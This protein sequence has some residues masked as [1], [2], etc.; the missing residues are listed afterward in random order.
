[1]AR[2]LFR[3][4]DHAGSIPVTPTNE[5]DRPPGGDRDF[6]CRL[7]WV[8]VPRLLRMLL[9]YDGRMPTCG[10]CSVRFPCR[11]TVGGVLRNVAGRKYCLVCSPFGRHNTTDPRVR[12]GLPVTCPCGRQFV[13]SK[14]KGHSHTKCNSCMSNAHRRGRKLRAIEYKGGKCE[15]C[16]Y[17]RCVGSLVFHHKD[18]A[19]KTFQVS[20]GTFSWE[21][22]RAEIDKCLLL[23][24][25]CHGEVHHTPL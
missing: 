22:V 10:L 21:R 2:H 20:F 18:P 6:T 1:M 8:R 23:C 15:M 9:C 14:S 16:G 7:R 12:T 5:G 17:S 25:N 24:A 11:V 13:Y 19:H 3:E 4:Q